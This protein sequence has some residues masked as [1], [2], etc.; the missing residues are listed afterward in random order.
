ML[1]PYDPCVTNKVIDVNQMTVCWH[2]DDLKVSLMDPEEMTK[3]ANW[4]SMTY[5]VS[6]ATHQGKVHSYFGMIFDFT[7][8]GKVVIN[9][10]I[11]IKNIISDFLE[12]ITAIWMSLAEFPLYNLLKMKLLG[13]INPNQVQKQT[14]KQCS[15]YIPF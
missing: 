1:N 9:M 15:L 8:K 11:Y 14:I 12:E 7:E 4:L 5:G 3:F 13:L 10:I 6:V 2:V